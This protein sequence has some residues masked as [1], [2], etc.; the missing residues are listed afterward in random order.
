MSKIALT[1][2]KYNNFLSDIANK[3]LENNVYNSS[4]FKDQKVEN[5]DKKFFAVHIRMGDWHKSANQNEN[6]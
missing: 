1:V 5:K 2:S 4:A 6:K 3:V